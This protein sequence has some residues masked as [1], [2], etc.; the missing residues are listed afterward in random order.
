MIR[1]ENN[2]LKC[3][4]QLKSHLYVNTSASFKNQNCSFRIT[5]HRFFKTRLEFTDA[6]AENKV[7]ETMYFCIRHDA[8]KFA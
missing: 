1:Q 5:K 3:T 2:L 7:G 8:E 6:Y 4:V